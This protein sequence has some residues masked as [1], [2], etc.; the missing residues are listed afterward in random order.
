[1]DIPGYNDRP[2]LFFDGVC[3]LCNS[4]VQFV[5]KHDRKKQVVFASLQS[6]YGEKAQEELRKQTG[7]V[8]DSLLLY[9]NNRFYTRSSA[10][11]KTAQLMGGAWGLSSAGFI[12]PPF[13]RNAVYDWIARNRY[14]W[15]GKR[16][17]CMIPTPELKARFLPG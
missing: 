10:A 1:M 3:N 15:Y 4:W 11:L 7:S 5:I 6:A 8:P 16:E 14:K 17:E 13:I 12:L 9:Y 2:I